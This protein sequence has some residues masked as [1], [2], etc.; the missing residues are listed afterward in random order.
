M[1]GA[2]RDGRGGVSHITPNSR[3]PIPKTLGTGTSRELE[4]GRWEFAGYRVTAA[5]IWRAE[6]P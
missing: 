1:A 3:L 4:A 6:M 2:A 5:T